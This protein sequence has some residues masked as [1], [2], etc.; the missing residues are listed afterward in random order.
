MYKTEVGDYLDNNLIKLKNYTNLDLERHIKNIFKLCNNSDYF[1]S[2]IIKLVN[3]HVYDIN[4]DHL[5]IFLS[6]LKYH[7]IEPF[8]HPTLHEICNQAGHNC[9]L[10][11]TL[12]YYLSIYKSL[13]KYKCNCIYN[14]LIPFIEDL[15]TIKRFRNQNE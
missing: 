8:H 13:N 5:N 4:S 7:P 14:L 11:K 6:K 9:K 1:Q 15:K 3:Y 12:E 10:S 2:T